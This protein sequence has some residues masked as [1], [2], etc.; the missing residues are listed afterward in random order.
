VKSEIISGKFNTAATNIN[1]N[2]T[3]KDHILHIRLMSLQEYY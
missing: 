3:H 1:V 2:Y